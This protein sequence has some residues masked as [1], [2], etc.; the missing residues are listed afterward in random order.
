MGPD[1]Q[2]LSTGRRYA[3]QIPEPTPSRRSTRAPRR[4]PARSDE[5]LR[6]LFE[7]C[8]RFLSG[9]GPRVPAAQLAAIPRDTVA[10]V[11][12]RGGVVADLEAQVATLLGKEAA[13][14]VITGTMA[15]QATLR[16][17]ADRRGSRSVAFHPACH[18]DVHEERAYERLHGLVGVT[19]GRGGE[20]LELADLEAVK[21]PLAALVLE[22]PQ[23]DLGG[24]LPAWDDLVAQVAW[25]RGIGAAVHLDGARLWEAWPHYAATAGKSLD[26]VAALFDTVY[27]SFYKGMGAIA[28]CCV[29][30]DKST[31]DELSVWRTRHGG[32][33]YGLWPYAASAKAAL[34]ERLGRFPVY[35]RR[36]V[37]LSRA[38]SRVDGV[39]AL[40]TPAQSAMLHVR[41]SGPRH[42]VLGRLHQVAEDEGVWLFA[43]PFA[44]EGPSLQRFEMTVG[45]ATMQLRVRD[46]ASLLERVVAP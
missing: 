38:L 36:A 5:Q 25:A 8:T 30:G 7:G 41:L 42:R 9:D 40:P 43:R 21:E 20:P 23:R 12:G 46:V 4:A 10:D 24:T 18:L 19:C 22:L 11:Y 17:H 16:V 28:G 34:D 39:E 31:I 15:Q 44:V 3:P 27:V 33:A 1:G 6:E 45:E 26:E 29:A 35:Y 32:R 37:Q 2:D 14:F 13:L